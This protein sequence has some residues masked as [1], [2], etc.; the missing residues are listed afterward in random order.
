MRGTDYVLI[1]AIFPTTQRYLV[2]ALQEHI[3]VLDVVH[4]TEAPVTLVLGVRDAVPNPD[5]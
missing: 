3:D 5:P 2:P 4:Q 1:D